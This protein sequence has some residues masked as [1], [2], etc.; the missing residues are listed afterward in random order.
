MQ[1]IVLIT[2]FTL[3]YRHLVVAVLLYIKMLFVFSTPVLI[4]HLWQL[5]TI[6][7]VYCCLIFAVLLA[8]IFACLLDL[9]LLE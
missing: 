2:R 7:F 4:R 1:T 5:K 8:D 6:V 3:T 9:S